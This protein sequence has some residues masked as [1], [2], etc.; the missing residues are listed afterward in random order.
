MTVDLD[1]LQNKLASLAD[2]G[3]KK[4]LAKGAEAAEAFVS[5]TDTIAI[6]IK[7]AVIEAKQGAPS[8]IGVRVV[9]DGKV[10]FAATSGTSEAQIAKIA[11]EAVAVARIRPLDPNFK[12]LPDLVKRSS[13]DG[14]IDD[15]VVQFSETQALKEVNML[16][17]TTFEHDKRI[18][19]LWGSVEVGRGAFA[20]ANSRGIAGAAKGAYIGAGIYCIA[21]KDGKQ[22]TGAEFLISRELADFGE[23]GTKAAERAV[24]MLE[25]KPLGKSLKTTT[26]WENV[27]IGLLL[28]SM[29]KTASNARNVQEGKSYFKE[30]VGERVAS[31]SLTIVDD[32]QLPEGFSTQKIDAEGIP[33]QTTTL[34]EKGVLKTHLYD[35]YSALR[36]NKVSSGN[37]KRELPEPFLKTPAVS[38]SNLVVKAGR[39]ELDDLVAEV[40]EGVLISDYV[41]GV[42]HANTITGEFSVVA[43]N[44]FLIEKGEV[45]N[46]LEPITV[47][48]NFFHALKRVQE[49]GCDTRLLEIGKIPSIIIGDLTASG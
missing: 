8:G 35:S 45:V 10:G 47:A 6:T 16:A 33:M 32:G 30:K 21:V 18:K 44:A 5:H 37:A 49:I 40:D 22:K 1:S 2:L 42:G 20:I 3:V 29:L 46:P 13:R 9:V 31:N 12:H 48:G 17:E 34:I 4:G 38:T 24:K 36:E 19:S 11:E 26:L 23:I 43:P 15:R 41:M 39:K 7:K 28:G 27:S 25:S 14:I